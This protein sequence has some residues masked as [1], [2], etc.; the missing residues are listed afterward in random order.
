MLDQKKIEDLERMMNVM[1]SYKEGK[2]VQIQ[3]ILDYDNEPWVDCKEPKWDWANYD[4]RIK[5][6]AEKI[7]KILESRQPETLV[8]IKMKIEELGDSGILCDVDTFP[9]FGEDRDYY[10][11]VPLSYINKKF[12]L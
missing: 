7:K 12:G 10:Y 6:D 11:L 1:K 8:Y 3:P 2:K 9:V 5:P 4:Y